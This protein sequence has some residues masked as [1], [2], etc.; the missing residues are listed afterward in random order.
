MS[1][2]TRRA[3]AEIGHLPDVIWDSGAPGKE[4]ML[5]LLGKS[6]TEVALKALRLARVLGDGKI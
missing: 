2:G 5:R 3:V 6:G 1:W 4:S